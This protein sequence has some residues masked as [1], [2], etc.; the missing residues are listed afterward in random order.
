MSALAVFTL[1]LIWAFPGGHEETVG[2][3][4]GVL[5]I[6]VAAVTLVTPVFHRLSHSDT[7]ADIDAEILKL[8]ERIRELETKRA[9]IENAE[10]P[11]L[12]TVE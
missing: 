12:S 9:G 6:L 10:Q 2:R 11:L 8:Q 4:L 1:Y 3:M 7:A 5:G